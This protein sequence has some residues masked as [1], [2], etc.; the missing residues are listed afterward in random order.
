MAVEDAG[1]GDDGGAST[2]PVHEG[3]GGGAGSGGAMSTPPVSSGGAGGTLD[4]AGSAAAMSNDMQAD[5]VQRTPRGGCSASRGAQAPAREGY[6]LGWLL[7]L[8]A[9]GAHMRRSAC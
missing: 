7:V 4:T 8:A 2:P 9:L 6:A 1:I 3:G 5:P